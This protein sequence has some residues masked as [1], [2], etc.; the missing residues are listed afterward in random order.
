MAVNVD[1]GLRLM[2]VLQAGIA[3]DIAKNILLVIIEG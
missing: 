1:L 3:L 2:K